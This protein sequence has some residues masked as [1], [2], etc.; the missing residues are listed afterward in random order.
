M[1]L[2]VATDRRAH[3]VVIVT[4]N[5]GLNALTHPVL[6][7]ELRTVLASSPSLVVLDLK[8]L[9]YINSLGVRLIHQTRRTLKADQ[10]ELRLLN[11]PPAIQRVF[12]IVQVLPLSEMFSS[13][14]ELD[15]YLD[16]VQKNPPPA[17]A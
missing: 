9:A 7:Q 4:P 15:A 12:E 5:G 16:Q 1:N 14:E 11:V 6:E 17:S 2:T 10:G 3:N 8:D 13:I